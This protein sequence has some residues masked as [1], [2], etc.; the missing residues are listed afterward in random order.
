MKTA[1]KEKGN[2]EK[3]EEL[4]AENRGNRKAVQDQTHLRENKRE[5]VKLYHVNSRVEK[6]KEKKKKT[7]RKQEM[8]GGKRTDGGK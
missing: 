8:K 3:N 1:V 7:L 6:K 2:T 5:E 4:E